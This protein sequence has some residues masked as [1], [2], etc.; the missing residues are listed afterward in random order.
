MKVLID[1]NVV[2]DYLADRMPFAD[3]AEQL[4]ELCDQG[5]IT[6]IITTNAITDIYYVV[7]KVAGKEKTLE[8]LRTLC[9]VL[10]IADVGKSDVL[11]AM[12]LDIPDFEDALVAQ[13]AK[14]VK[15][16]CIVTRNT[17]DFKSS[18]VPAKEPA[19]LLKQ[20]A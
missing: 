18:P 11:G 15:A 12:E 9:S 8:S 19:A 13:C 17:S 5:T 10:E 14:K 6:G 20:L 3:H 16:E 1:T 4:L 7:R 2:I